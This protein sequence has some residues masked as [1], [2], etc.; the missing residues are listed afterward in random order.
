MRDR[1][2][3]SRARSN[4][5]SATKSRSL[6]ASSELSNGLAKPS[7]AAV[8]AG[9]IGSDV[10]AS[11]PAPSGETSSRATVA[12]SRSTSRAERPAVGEQVVGQQHRL[13]PLQVGVA[14]QVASPRRLGAG[15]QHVLQGD[16]RRAA[17]AAQLALAPQP[18]VGGHLVVAAAA[19]VQLGAGGA[20]ELG[21]AP[22]DGGVDV[23]VGLRRTRTRPSPAPARRSSSAASTASRSASVEQ[24][25][26]RR[27]R[28]TWARE[29]AMSS[30]HRRRS[31]GRLDGERHQRVGRAAG[32]AAVPQRRAVA[33]LA[34]PSLVAGRARRASRR[35]VGERDRRRCSAAATHISVSSPATVPSSPSMR[36]A[37]ERRRHDVGA[38]RRRAQRRRGCRRR[39]PR[40]PTRRAPGAAGRTGRCGRARSRGGRTRSAPPG[41]RTLIDAELVEVARHRRLR[42]P[43]CPRRPSSSSS[44]GWLV[45][46]VLAD[47]AGRSPAGAATLVAHASRRR[48]DEEG[49][50]RRGRRGGGCGPAGTPG[51]AAR[52]SRRPA[53]SSPRYAGRQCMN[54]ASARPRAISASSTVNPSNACAR[55]AFSSSWPIDTHVSAC[56]ASAP[57]TASAGRCDAS[58]SPRRAAASRSSSASSASKPGGQ[59]NATCAPSIARDLGRASG[60][61]CCS[62]RPRRRVRPASEPSAC[63]IVSASASACSGWARSDSRLTIGTSATAAM[64][65]S[66]PWSNTRAAITAW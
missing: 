5:A 41:T 20:G 11:A 15:E 60:R 9:S 16:A 12:S 23:L 42:R 50:Q 51:C 4:S 36:A 61:R 64:R 29:P 57:V 2:M 44:C 63:S 65:S 28:A 48:P 3:P 46:G 56:T 31:N 21:D 55:C 27:G 7:S 33:G 54:T 30:R 1:W 47:A 8:D 45:T 37:V 24:A 49:E 6:T 43:R 18:Q 40:P 62:R 25:D 59:A 32:E 53:T 35:S 14:G 34:A 66:T 17:T 26:A 39:R 52:R 10:P 19:G 58:T 38:A 22:L 13:G